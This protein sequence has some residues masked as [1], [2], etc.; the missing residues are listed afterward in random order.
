LEE[1][2]KKKTEARNIREENKR[3][4]GTVAVEKLELVKVL[5]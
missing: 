5:K 4:L 1:F 3:E 2:R